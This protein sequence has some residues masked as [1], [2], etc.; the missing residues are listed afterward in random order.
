MS[1]NPE[2][3]GKTPKMWKIYMCTFWPFPESKVKTN[4]FRKSLPLSKGPIS[5]MSSFSFSGRKMTI[6]NVPRSRPGGVFM[7]QLCLNILL[8]GPFSC[9]ATLAKMVKMAKKRYWGEKRAIA[10]TYGQEAQIWQKGPNPLISGKWAKRHFLNKRVQNARFC[11]ISQN[12]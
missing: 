2:I 3:S 1:W 4:T 11:P 8:F 7:G 12:I 9:F 5:K 10:K 6:K